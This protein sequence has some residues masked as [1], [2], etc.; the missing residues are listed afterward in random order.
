MNH[1]LETSKENLVPLSISESFQ[2]ALSEWFFTGLVLDY[3]GGEIECE[4][5]EHPDLSHHYEIKNK[6]NKN[7]LLVGS[8][9]ILKF[10]KISIL[11]ENGNLVTEREARKASLDRALKDKLREIMLEPLRKLW[12]KNK[13]NRGFI[14]SNAKQLKEGKSVSPKTLVQLFR[15]MQS[16]G[17][18]YKPQL[19]KVSLRSYLDQFEMESMS[20]ADRALILHSLSQQQLKKLQKLN[21]SP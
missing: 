7:K 19:Y 21:L 11:D 13:P 10:Q 2:D 15:L 4:L 9:C 5:C 1:W 16:Q 8:S 20:A 18:A 6:N 14:E 12:L 17:L 3:D